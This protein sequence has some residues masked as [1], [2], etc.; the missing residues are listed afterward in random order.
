MLA[1]RSMQ[2][3]VLAFDRSLLS[4][5]SKDDDGHLH[6]RGTPISKAMVCPYLGSEIPLAEQMGL[7]PTKVYM[8]LRDPEALAKG[9]ATFNNK[10]LLDLHKTQTARSYDH[11][12][13]VG[14]VSNPRFEA[15]YLKA[16][17]TVWE[18]AAIVAIEQDVLRE[19]SSSYR[20]DADMT[21]P[22]IYLG[23]PYDGVM[24]NIRGNHVALV[25]DGRAGPDVLVADGLPEWAFK[26]RQM[27]NGK[28]QFISSW[29]HK[30]H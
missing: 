25:E 15:P 26:F 19:L 4:A 17:L 3:D 5:R 12:L 22:G 20:Y 9:A 28:P 8:L 21:T 14:T 11:E 23:E 24:R 18:A 16:D 10:Q 13:T 29:R 7:T 30:F 6:V 2:Q 27:R 1:F